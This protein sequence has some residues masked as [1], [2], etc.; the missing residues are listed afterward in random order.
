M[1]IT[2]PSSG[3]APVTASNSI[4]PTA[5]QSAAGVSARPAACS[6]AMY[7][8]VPTISWSR[9]AAL[10]WSTSVASPKSR[11]T[12][13]PSGVTRR[14]LGLM[15]RCTL[16]DS[17]SAISPRVSCTRHERTR[18]SSRVPPSRGRTQLLGLSAVGSVGAVFSGSAAT[19]LVGSRPQPHRPR[20][21]V[22]REVEP[23]DQPYGEEPGAVQAVPRSYSSTRLGCARFCSERNSC[24]NS[25]SVS[26]LKVRS[27]FSA[28][29]A[30]VSRSSAS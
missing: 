13:C 23:V 8:T 3:S 6:G 19:L 7:A 4:T 20:P 29:L 18:P 1:S 14:L 15:S 17:C 21:H 22:G 25:K 5:Y 24:L 9:A 28:T 11:I 26:G 10:L 12:T 2:L 27:V 30:C 16:P